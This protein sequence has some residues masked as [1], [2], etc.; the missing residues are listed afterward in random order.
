MRNAVGLELD[1]YTWQFD[2]NRLAKVF[3]PKERKSLLKPYQ[4]DSLD[5]YVD[6]AITKKILRKAVTSFGKPPKIPKSDAESDHYEP[7]CKILNKCVEACHKALGDSKGEYYRGLK[8]VK[9]DKP[10]Q[11]G[12]SGE[13]RL[14]PDL[15]GGIDLPGRNEIKANAGLYWR[16]PGLNEHELLLPVEVKRGWNDLVRQAGTYARCLFM[17][18]PLRKFALVL[19]YEHVLQEFRILV[20]HRGG[21]TSSHA[22]KFEKLDANGIEDVLHIFLSILSWKTVADA[23]LPLWCNDSN[24]ILPGEKGPQAVQMKKVL[25][26]TVGLRGRCARVVLVCEVDESNKRKESKSNLTIPAPESMCTLRRSPR[27][28]SQGGAVG[29]PGWSLSSFLVLGICAY[30]FIS[31]LEHETYAQDG[32]RCVSYYRFALVFISSYLGSKLRPADEKRSTGVF[33]VIP[34]FLCLPF[35]IRLE[36]GI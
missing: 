34:L 31:S 20:F 28:Q 6:N 15:A 13:H 1:G 2:T 33:H 8:F 3:L 32:N 30:H 14:K 23:G 35:V 4:V 5:A 25:H 22:L 10:T 29:K 24:I 9:W 18:S 27:L 36:I 16:R 26:E 7:L 19:G 11:D 21:L 17:A 12:C